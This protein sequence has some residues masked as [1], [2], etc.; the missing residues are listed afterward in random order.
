MPFAA[1]WLD[2]ERH[3][4]RSQSNREGETLTDIPYMWNLKRNDTNELTTQKDSEN[5]LLW[6]QHGG[7]ES[8]G[9]WEAPVH[10]AILNMDNQQE[11][12]IQHV[13]LCSTLSASLDGRGVWER[14]DTC[15]W[16][17]ESLC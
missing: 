12:P 13:E 2:K 8:K 17:A 4:K 3:T 15:V 14:I 9:L 7:W 11:P 16:M 5:K 6:L 10:T 1:A